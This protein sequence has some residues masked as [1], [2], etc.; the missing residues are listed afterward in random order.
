MTVINIFQKLQKANILQQISEALKNP[1]I[2][3]YEFGIRKLRH[4]IYKNK[5]SNQ[6]V[7]PKYEIPYNFPEQQNMLLQLYC[8]L[9]QQMNAPSRP[10][11]LIF[12]Q[13]ET[14]AVL[15]WVR[16]FLYFIS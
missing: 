10:L 1:R 12:Q 11:K 6:F 15:G 7:F 14:E 5:N 2:S 4:F 3:P 16:H 13:L 8:H 9:Y